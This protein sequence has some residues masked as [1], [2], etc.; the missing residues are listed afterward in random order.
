M[1]RQSFSKI[2]VLII[3]ISLAIG[4]V[5]IFDSVKEANAANINAGSLTIS[6]VGDKLFSEK[7]L[8]PGDVIV[9]DLTVTNNG[10]KPHSF[11]ISVGGASGALAQVLQ[12]EPRE[13]GS[14]IW[15]QTLSSLA[16]LPN[17]SRVILP[18]IAAKS[19]RLIQIA[20]ILP[21]GI[22]NNFQAKSTLS[23]S[24]IM[25]NESTDAPESGSSQSLLSAISQTLGTTN[26][27]VE[28]TPE[29]L[30]SVAP[31]DGSSQNPGESAVKGASSSSTMSWLWY[32]IPLVFIFLLIMFLLFLRR[33]NRPE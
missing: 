10:L 25:G 17:G 16:S 14:A 15:N 22:D 23:F 7:N 32:G 26:N 1:K 18:S 28:E 31:P 19:S 13:N 20:A 27:P 21:E 2:S 3:L 8:S 33:R 24:F 30:N 29:N 6:F 11:S 12:I 9:K 5:G 4:A